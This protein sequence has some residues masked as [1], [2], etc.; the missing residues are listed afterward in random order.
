MQYHWLNKKNNENLIVFF[1]GWSFDYIPF[2]FIDCKNYDVLAVYDY[3]SL[4]YN[5]PDIND[6]AKKYL[7]GWSMGVFAAY[8]LKDKLPSFD[9]KVAVNGTVYPV[10][11]QYGI[12]QKT[13]DLTLKYADT[14]LQGKFY[15]NVFCNDEW[16]ERYMKSPVK[17]TIED[18]VAELV[19][20]NQFVKNTTVT[21]DNKFYNKA[22]VGLT[23][24]IIPA[25]N[26]LAFW[27]DK[28]QT[29]DCG[30]FPF[31]NY[32]SWDEICN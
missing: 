31:Y 12:P 16:F 13:F 26:Q 6:Y 19:S 15:K 23:D 25:K 11:D 27:K 17:R 5:L 24:K 4:E 28:A 20:L 9:K 22:I 1:A 32:T 30:H 18:R 10:D 8:L 29:I 21:Y 7:I 2:E 14:G 3:N